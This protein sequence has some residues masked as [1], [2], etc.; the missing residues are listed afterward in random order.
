M[1]ILPILLLGA[2]I[3]GKRLFWS[4]VGGGEG[5]KKAVASLLP[6]KWLPGPVNNASSNR[7]GTT[8]GPL[9]PPASANGIKVDG[10][11]IS[12]RPAATLGFKGKKYTVMVGD[13]MELPFTEGR[14]TVRCEKIEGLS[15]GLVFPRN[16]ARAEFQM[17][18]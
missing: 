6:E 7:T 17:A 2:A 9:G 4:S 14:E 15:V 3:A 11:I 1:V 10:I 12:A 8:V 13:E 18:R 5:I 16:N